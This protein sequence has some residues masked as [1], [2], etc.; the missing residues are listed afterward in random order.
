MVGGWVR[1][2]IA[3]ARFWDC[4]AIQ[5]HAE[6]QYSYSGV[7]IGQCSGLTELR[8]VSVVRTTDSSGD[9]RQVFLIRDP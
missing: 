6:V 5:I 9:D 4:T 2:T 7:T 1:V 8:R 3:H